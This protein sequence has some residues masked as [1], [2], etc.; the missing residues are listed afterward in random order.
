MPLTHEYK[1]SQ[2]PAQGED[3]AHRPCGDAARP[4]GNP[5][6]A[7][8]PLVRVRVGVRARVRIRVRVRFWVR[9]RVSSQGQ[10]QA[11]GGVPG[12]GGRLPRASS[13]RRTRRRAAAARCPSRGRGCQ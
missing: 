10:G 5:R 13:W 3:A 12:R 1:W 2:P 8:P 4:R 9:V 6:L 11:P 7:V